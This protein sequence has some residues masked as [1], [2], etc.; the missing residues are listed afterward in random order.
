MRRIFHAVLL[1]A[2]KCLQLY[3]L[4]LQTPRN[5]KVMDKE[6]KHTPE[7]VRTTDAMKD[8]QSRSPYVVAHKRVRL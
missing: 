7:R 3:L 6:K 2:L 5:K 1:K 4:E 8:A